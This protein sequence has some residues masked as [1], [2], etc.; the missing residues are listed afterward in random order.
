MRRIIS[1]FLLFVCLQVVNTYAD[2]SSRDIKIV[3]GDLEKTMSG[4]KTIQT[5]FIQEKN[6]ALFKQKFTLKGKIFI[7][8]PV[9]LSWRVF[10]PILPA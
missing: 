7:Q 3:L 2:N 4:T 1:S 5:D 10:T 9:M 6:L 8:K